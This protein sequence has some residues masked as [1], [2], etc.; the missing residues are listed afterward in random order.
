MSFILLFDVHC[1]Q[2]SSETVV[3]VEFHPLDPGALI[4]CGKGRVVFQH[5]QCT[6][7]E[8]LGARNRLGIGLRT[9]PPGYTAWRNWFFGIDSWA[10]SNF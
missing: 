3:S 10:P 4:T 2:C 6:V 9:D 7:L 1:V 8:F 5:Q